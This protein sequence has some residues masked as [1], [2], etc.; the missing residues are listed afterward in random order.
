M[1]KSPPDVFVTDNVIPAYLA[2]RYVKQAGIPCVGILRSDDPFYHGIIE[3]FV[4]G[5]V[6][7]RVNSIVCVSEFL[8]SQ[9]RTGEDQSV[10]VR[11]IPSGTPIPPEVTET[12]EE[13][14]RIVYVGR[15]VEEQKQILSTVNSL[16]KATRE[17]QGVEGVVYGDGPDKE[18][19]ESLLANSG[20][21]VVLGGNLSSK[22]LQRRLLE[23][24][25]ILLLSDYEGT[26][27]AVMEAMACGVVPVCLNIRSGIPELVEHDVTGLLVNDRGDSV[28]H[29][30]RRLKEEP[31]LWERLSIGARKRA[32]EQFAFGRC[33]DRWAE[34]INQMASESGPKSPVPNPRRLKLARR[35]LGFAHQHVLAPSGIEK[36]LVAAQQVYRRSRMW[37]GKIRRKLR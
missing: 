3:T 24:H 1:Q 9:A 8:A 35:H 18:R 2:V 20:A 11:R 30:I 25:V 19:V 15:L 26:P 10:D 21:H 6:E 32:E 22:E 4:S 27:T 29:A 33:A 13:T 31:G 12:P 36:S 23:S 17:V 14:L 7:D 28:V 34:L 37:L 5:R 16:I